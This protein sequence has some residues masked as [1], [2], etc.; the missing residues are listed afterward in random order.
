MKKNMIMKGMV[1]GIIVL[2][3]GAGV[4]PS[5]SGNIE[6]AKGENPLFNDWPCDPVFNGTM[7]EGGWFITPVNV[8]FI[9]DPEIVAEIYYRVGSGEWTLYTE[10]FVIYE[11]GV[12]DFLFRWVDY[13]G[14]HY[15][16]DPM[17]LRIDYSPPELALIIP[18]KGGVYLFGKLVFE[19]ESAST[20]I[21]G[22][23]AIDVA[24]IDE[25]SG[26][27]NITFSLV[28]N[29]K[30]PETHVSETLPY[31]WELTGR[32]IGKYTLTVTAYDRGGL[33]INTTLNMII[34]Q[35]GIL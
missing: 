22:K 10:P 18:E 2:F 17:T 28:K 20:I 15:T 26:I 25:L 3:V 30:P 5:I 35:F 29:S 21:L 13:N 9:Y 33:S 31:V 7:C 8:S 6:E 24:T 4:V 23:I 11:Q 19:K 32:H 27:D 34:F 12:V 16:P 14:N 1:I